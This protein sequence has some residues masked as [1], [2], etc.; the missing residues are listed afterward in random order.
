MNS[1]QKHNIVFIVIDTHRRDRLGMYGYNRNTSP[2]LDEFASKATIYDHAVSPAQWTIPAHASMFSGEYPSTHLTT[3]SGHSLD[4]YFRTLAELLS[5][6]DYRRIGF[7]NNPLVGVIDNGLKR[8]FD[9]FYNYGGAFPSIPAR[10]AKGVIAS[11]SKMGERY[12]QLLRRISYPIQNAVAR[13]EKVLDF[14]LNP[15]FVPLWTSLA[16]FKGNTARSIEDATTYLRKEVGG[17][18]SDQH[19]VFMNLMEPHLPFTPPEPF[20]SRF[21]PYLKK[22]H[23]ARDFMRVYNTKALRWL[24]PMDEPFSELEFRTLSDFYDAEVA[25]QDHLLGSLLNELNSFY[26]RENTMVIIV[27]DHGEML[28]EHQ[29][30]GHSFR[31]FQELIQVPLVIRFPGDCQGERVPDVISTNQLFHTVLDYAG[32]LTKEMEKLGNVDDLFSQ[33]YQLSLLSHRVQK[34]AKNNAA[35]SESYPPDNVIKI[36]EKHDPQL[37]DGFQARSTFRAAYDQFGYKLVRA[38]G[39]SDSMYNIDVDKSERDEIENIKSNPNYKFL[40]N[41]LDRFMELSKSRQP[42]QWSRSGVDLDD[43]AL[44]QRLRNLGYME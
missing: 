28:G 10:D 34:R 22:E 30:M 12:T 13:S 24:L 38:D 37:I 39:F 17:D 11:L 19:F 35:F 27:A 3:Q 43:E 21:V 41:A 2:N 20:V 29:F 42:E 26:H 25:Y 23:A 9:T 33:V 5:L 7:C 32:V 8:G 6:A 18:D 44:R 14:S 1:E 31:V 40:S 15:I 16:N 36:L 4:P